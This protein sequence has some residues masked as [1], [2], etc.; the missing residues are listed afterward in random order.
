MAL[1]LPVVRVTMYEC[2]FRDVV[3]IGC[4]Y[5]SSLEVLHREE[6]QVAW[7]AA[8]VLVRACVSLLGRCS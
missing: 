2:L 8:L 5:C 7:A 4:C 6:N 1:P 3:G